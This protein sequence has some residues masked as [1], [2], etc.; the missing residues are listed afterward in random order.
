[1]RWEGEVSVRSV[2]GTGGKGIHEAGTAGDHDIL[3]IGKRLEL[4][5]AG[6]NGS[7]LPDAVVFEKGVVLA[8]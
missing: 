8:S 7:S 1:M 6:E 5:R 2:G 3:D 4:G